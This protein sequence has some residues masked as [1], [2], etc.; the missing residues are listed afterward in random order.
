MVFIPRAV[1]QQ[2]APPVPVLPVPVASL[3][4][5]HYLVPNIDRPLFNK[6]GRKPW[7]F[8]RLDF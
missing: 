7:I 1:I 3:G 4:T 5:Y 8:N 6:F 2:Q